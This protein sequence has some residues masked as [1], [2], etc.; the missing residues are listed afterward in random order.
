MKNTAS[1]VQTALMNFIRTF[2]P[3]L[4]LAA[5]VL[6]VLDNHSVTKQNAR[7][8]SQ[9]ASHHIRAKQQ[10]VCTSATVGTRH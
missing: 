8:V 3:S 6:I 1:N 4:M 9:E 7:I 5:G 2:I 10:V